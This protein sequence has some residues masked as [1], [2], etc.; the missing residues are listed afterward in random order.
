MGDL[1]PT[2]QTKRTGIW[3]YYEVEC[4]ACGFLQWIAAGQKATLC[5]MCG[6]QAAA[7]AA[8]GKADE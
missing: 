1:L 8:G 5:V 7:D 2:G 6:E 4:L 3:N